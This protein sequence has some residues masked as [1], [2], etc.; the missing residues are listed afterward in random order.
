MHTILRISACVVVA[1]G[2][3]FFTEFLLLDWQRI[4]RKKEKTGETE[5]EKMGKTKK[6]SEANISLYV[7][8]SC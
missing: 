5:E 3:N 1:V 6:E 2:F 8:Y 4:L 7:Q